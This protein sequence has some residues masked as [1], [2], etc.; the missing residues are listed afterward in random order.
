MICA[1]NP[2][3]WLCP[4]DSAALEGRTCSASESYANGFAGVPS[5]EFAT[6]ALPGLSRPRV[7]RYFW[8]L[9]MSA[10]RPRRQLTALRIVTTASTRPPWHP[11]A[12]ALW[13]CACAPAIDSLCRLLLAPEA[14]RKGS[15]ASQTLRESFPGRRPRPFSSIN[16]QSPP[17]S[18]FL[19]PGWPGE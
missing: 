16:Y 17:L 14:T 12:A 10:Q 11:D 2:S 13:H 18:L 19:Q 7:G 4:C 6:S 1:L 3:T 5:V 15:D 9:C 8:R